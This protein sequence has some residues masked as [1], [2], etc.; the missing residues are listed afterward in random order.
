MPPVEF[1]PDGPA[2]SSVH[3]TDRFSDDDKEARRLAGLSIRE[4]TGHTHGRSTNQRGAL[5][6]KCK[7]RIRKMG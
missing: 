4:A 5:L 2:A 6:A 7:G 3:L 1:D